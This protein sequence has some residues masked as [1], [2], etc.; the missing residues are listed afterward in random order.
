MHPELYD[1]DPERDASDLA[2]VHLLLAKRT[3]ALCICRGMQVLNVALGGS[4]HQNVHELP[5]KNEHRMNRALPS[6]LRVQ[7]RHP[8]AIQPGGMLERLMGRTGEFMVNSLHAQGIDRLLLFPQ[9]P[10]YAMSSW[11]TV[12]VKVHREAAKIA[13]DMRIECVLPYYGDADYIAA[14]VARASN[15]MRFCGSSLSE[16]VKR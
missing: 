2:L 4:L 16:S 14:L 13:P 6:E 10:H 8:V 15:R 11:E 9:Y 3:P 12:V 1:L 5:G 7:V